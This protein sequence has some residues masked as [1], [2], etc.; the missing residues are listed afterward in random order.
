[1]L[2]VLSLLI[3]IKK[4]NTR[5][6]CLRAIL[7]M[8][9]GCND[10]VMKTPAIKVVGPPCLCNPPALQLLLSQHCGPPSTRE[11]IPVFIVI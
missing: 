1:M 4:E 9:R 5:D 10:D 6:H 8:E 7:R 11:D 3:R 2:L